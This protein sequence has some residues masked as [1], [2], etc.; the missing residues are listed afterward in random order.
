MSFDFINTESETTRER[1]EKRKT[2]NISDEM[3]KIW[4]FA[5]DNLTRVQ[6]NQKKF[7]DRHQKLTSIYE[8]RNKAYLSIKNIRIERSLKKLNNK[9]LNLYSVRKSTQNNVQLELS[10]FMKIHN[11][12]YISL[13]KS[14]AKIFL[15]EQHSFV[16]QSI[17]INDEEEYE[18]DDILN[19]RR[20]RGKI[21]YKIS[22]M[23]YS[24]DRKWY[25]A[26]NFKNA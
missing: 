5:I 19:S 9:I 7:V 18:I 4:E 16:A 21:Q 23:N 1:I 6:I 12:F 13:I 22:W 2:K 11:P 17:I 8:S 26:E 10:N 20:F 24:F 3:K 14:A 25:D 15:F